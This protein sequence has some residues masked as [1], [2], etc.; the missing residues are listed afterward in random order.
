VW[1]SYSI[2]ILPFWFDLIEYSLD[3]GAENYKDGKFGGGDNSLG[4]FQGD[5]FKSWRYREGEDGLPESAHHVHF[6]RGEAD[7]VGSADPKLE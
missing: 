5:E 6:S 4:I 1:K 7:G 3:H 2:G